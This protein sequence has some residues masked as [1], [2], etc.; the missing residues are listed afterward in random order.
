MTKAIIKVAAKTMFLWMNYLV[1]II[2]LRELDVYV[3]L[4]A[5]VGDDGTL[6]A[7]D[8]R[9]ILGVHSDGQLEARKSLQGTARR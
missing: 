4:G 2:L 8:L 3:M 6:T 1:L 7:D 9:V 5:D